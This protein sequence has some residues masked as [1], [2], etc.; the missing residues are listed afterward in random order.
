[1]N[2]IQEVIDRLN[3]KLPELDPALINLYALL[4]QVRPFNCTTEDVHDAW[5]IWKNITDPCH[6]SLIPFSALSP[7]VQELD[8]KYMVAIREVALDMYTK[9]L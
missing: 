6:K 2:Y 8:H 7:E 4:V 1:M 5:S 9:S 3:E